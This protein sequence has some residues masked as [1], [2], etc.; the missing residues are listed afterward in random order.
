MF[1]IELLISWF[2]PIRSSQGAFEGAF[3]ATAVV[4]YVRTGRNAHRL[5]DLDDRSVI[6]YLIRDIEVP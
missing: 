1:D 5:P 6:R 4:R 2:S 3:V